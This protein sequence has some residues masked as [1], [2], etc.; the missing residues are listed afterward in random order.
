MNPNIFNS[1]GALTDLFN[2]LKEK[3][4]FGFNSIQEMIDYKKSYQD[5]I[6]KIKSEKT[7][8]VIL[9]IE[10]LEKTCENVIQEYETAKKDQIIKTD[11]EIEQLN[12]LYNDLNDDLIS[13]IR[14]CFIKNKLRKYE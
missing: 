14:K 5:E 10:T 1:S 6:Q 8:E 7:K 3:S 13:K 4:V 2:N 9:E 11:N 12:K